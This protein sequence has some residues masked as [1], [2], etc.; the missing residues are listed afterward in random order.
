MKTMSKVLCLALAAIMCV[1]AFASCG[2]IDFS[3]ETFNLGATGPLTGDVSSYG[4]SVN[5]GAKLA[6]KELNAAGGING[7]KISYT[8]LD[9]EGAAQKATK[10][11]NS[12]FK[13]GMQVSLGSVTSGACEAFA[14][15]AAEENVFFITPSASA[16]SIIE[17]RKNGF[18]VCFGDP[19][20]GVLAAQT[21]KA[22]LDAGELSKIGAI[23]DSSDDYSKGIFEAFKKEMGT[24]P[25]TETSFDADNK[26]DFSSQ[27]NTL[28]DCDLIFM[29]FYYTE[30]ALVAEE[31]AKKECKATLFGCDGFDGIKLSDAVTNKVSYITPFDAESEQEN[32]KKFVAAYKAEYGVAPDQFAAD[33]YDAV[34]AIAVAMTKAGCKD[35]S[36]SAADLNKILYDIMT[37]D[38]FVFE[39]VTGSMIWNE[40]GEPDKVPQIK[41]YKK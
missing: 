29:P 6:V 38:G 9:D 26:T 7:I 32:V 14:T 1:A 15:R 12:L 24:T 27:V 22:A 23:Y 21:I 39:G 33:G 25:F 31:C 4:I 8:M 5:N 36:I 18:R 20:Q 41:E 16:A 37:A 2:G 19:D 30:A 40:K 13:K 11:F 10:G 3:E 35:A 17:N 28:K 34:M